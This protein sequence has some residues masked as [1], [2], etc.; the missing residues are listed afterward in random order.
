MVGAHGAA[1]RRAIDDTGVIREVISRLG[2]LEREMLPD[3]SPTVDALADR[4]ANLATTLHRLELDV[5]GSTLGALDQ[6][7][8]AMKGEPGSGEHERTLSLLERQRASLHDLLIRRQALIAQLDSAGLA[9]QNLKLD[10]LKLR[11]AGVSAAMGGENSAT[12]EARSVSKD[13]GRIIEVADD[14]R[15]IGRG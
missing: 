13:I 14:M 1:V 15:D 5:S 6:R 8:A 11:S 7:I 12:Q 10:L 4:V 2:P 3:V 9:L